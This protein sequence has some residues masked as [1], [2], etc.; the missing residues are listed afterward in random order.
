MKQLMYF[1]KEALKQELTEDLRWFVDNATLP[2]KYEDE[3][4]AF[5]ALVV[6]LWDRDGRRSH[7]ELSDAKVAELISSMIKR[8]FSRNQYQ[9]AFVGKR[10]LVELNP[11]Q[12]SLPKEVVRAFLTIALENWQVAFF[13]E[14]R[15]IPYPFFD[16][17]ERRRIVNNAVEAMCRRGDVYCRDKTTRVF[18]PQANILPILKVLMESEVTTISLHQ[19]SALVEAI[20]L[21]GLERSLTPTLIRDM[22]RL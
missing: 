4:G 10:K 18:R 6:N 12:A 17:E 8:P 13:P 15:L 5:L 14:A 9:Y 22:L 1:D 2:D 19:V 3:P 7:S 11:R 21:A 16:Y 20:H